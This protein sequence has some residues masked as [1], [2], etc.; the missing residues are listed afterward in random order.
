M[1]ATLAPVDPR[2]AL[3]LP[4]PTRPLGKFGWNASLLTLG[5]VKWDTQCSDSEAA[6]LVHRAIELG[7]NTFDTAFIYGEGESERK[8]GI[9]LEGIRHKVWIN[10]KIIDRTYDGAM[11]QMETS[12][13]RLRTDYVDLMFVHS[14]DSEEQYHEIVSPNSVVKAILEMKAAGRVGHIGVSGHWVKHVMERIIQEVDFEAVLCPV[15]LFNSAYNYRFVDNVLP[16]A[17]KRD[18]AVLGMKV[19]GAGRVQ[20][21]RSV[22]PYLRYSLHQ[23]VD[24]CVI[25]CDSI[26]QLE[27]TVG[28]IKSEPPPLTSSEMDDLVPE[29][30]RVTQQFEGGEFNWVSHYLEAPR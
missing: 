24:T 12:M 26:A 18:M 22:A 14:V 27:E 29:A 6:A 23:D 25:G 3:T 10:T 4:M 7:V 1:S 11:K 28:I 2:A 5:G 16:V 9:A 17:R 19:Y 20:H 13:K 8:L 30:L 21:A 15:G